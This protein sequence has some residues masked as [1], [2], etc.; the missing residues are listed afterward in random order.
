MDVSTA[1]YIA[2]FLDGDGSIHF[3]LVRQKEY[4]FGFY[5]RASVSFSQSTSARHGLERIQSMLGGG[6][7]LRDRGTG[8]SDLVITSRAIVVEILQEVQPYVIFKETHVRR[9]LELLPLLRGVKDPE[10]L[11]HLA[12]QVDAFATLNYSKSKRISAVDVEQHLR[13]MGVLCPCNDFFAS[14]SEE[15]ASLD[16]NLGPQTPVEAIT[17]QPLERG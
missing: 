10:V 1:S 8:M 14:N 11:L 7:Y 2:G 9:A 13:S 17:R 15:M 12:H 6:G 3:Q 5:I 4:R 16:R